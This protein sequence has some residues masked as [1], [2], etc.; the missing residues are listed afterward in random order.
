VVRGIRGVYGVLFCQK[1]LKLSLLVDECKPLLD[2]RWT[3]CDPA[4]LYTVQFHSRNDGSKRVSITTWRASARALV[5]G[6]A[7]GAAVRIFQP[8]TPAY[9]ALL[10]ALRWVLFWRTGGARRGLHF[11]TFL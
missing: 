9:R 10:R 6:L 8:S 2:M 3:M 11:T 5:E 7:S 4:P 1:R